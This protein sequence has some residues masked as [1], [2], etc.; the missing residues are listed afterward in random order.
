[1]NML[2]EFNKILPIWL[3]MCCDWAQSD[4]D[5]CDG[6]NQEMFRK[7][8][9]DSSSRNNE[10]FDVYKLNTDNNHYHFHTA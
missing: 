2:S 9:Q 10:L 5:W 1:M 4:G 3:K 8:N 7:S 6:G